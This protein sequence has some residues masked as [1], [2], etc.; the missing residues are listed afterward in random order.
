MYRELELLTMAGISPIEA[1][2]ICTYNGAKI[3]EE[4]HRYGSIQEGLEADLMLVSGKP[5]ENISDTRNIKH[6]FLKENRERKIVDLLE[7]KRSNT[8]NMITQIC[9]LHLECQ[10]ETCRHAGQG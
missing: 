1:I 8:Y 9:D 2:K 7:I 3:L 4:D 10:R 5:W 6:V